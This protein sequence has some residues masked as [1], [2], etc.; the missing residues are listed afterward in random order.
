MIKQS[1]NIGVVTLQTLFTQGGNYISIGT[2]GVSAPLGLSLVY[3]PSKGYGPLEIE[4]TALIDGVIKSGGTEVFS[5]GDIYKN[6][7]LWKSFGGP[8]GFNDATGL[9]Y[10]MNGSFIDSIPDNSSQIT[11]S[12]YGNCQKTG[13][14]SGVVAFNWGL[15]PP[16]APIG[17]G[18]TA[19]YMRLIE[20]I[21]S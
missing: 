6:G 2:A 18:T 16:S 8:S 13:S 11:Y 4:I 15:N 1:R 3:T 14:G 20:R 21:K 12:V 19:T 7:V 5:R 9:G 10:Q 17:G